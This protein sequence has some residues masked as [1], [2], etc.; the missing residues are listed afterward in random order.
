MMKAIRRPATMGVLRAWSKDH[1][2]MRRGPDVE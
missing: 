1:E 2:E